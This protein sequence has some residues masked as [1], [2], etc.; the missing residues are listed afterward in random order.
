M[1]STTRGRHGDS[2]QTVKMVFFSKMVEVGR[3]RVDVLTYLMSARRPYPKDRI[4]YRVDGTNETLTLA[5]L[6]RKNRQLA[7]HLYDNFGIRAGDVVAI[8]AKDTVSPLPELCIMFSSFT[9]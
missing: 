1:H 2:S 8:C 7:Q 5:E 6:E 4:M 3:P 9:H